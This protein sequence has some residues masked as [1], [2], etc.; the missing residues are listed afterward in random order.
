MVLSRVSFYVLP[1]RIAMHNKEKWHLQ[2]NYRT[3]LDC[4]INKLCIGIVLS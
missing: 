1:T 4:H 3:M 2:L